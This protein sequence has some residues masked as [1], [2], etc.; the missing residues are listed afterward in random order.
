MSRS[1]KTPKPWCTLKISQH[2]TFN[3]SRIAVQ[4]LKYPLRQ[5]RL[6][7]FGLS[8]GFLSTRN[9]L[10]PL[11]TST[12]ITGRHG[13]S[14]KATFG[15]FSLHTD[16]PGAG[17]ESKRLYQKLAQNLLHSQS[18]MMSRNGSNLIHEL[19][20]NKLLVS[21]HARSPFTKPTISPC[22]RARNVVVHK[23]KD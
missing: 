16:M 4:G 10:H 9:L 17:Y 18:V 6:M 3:V 2:A 5:P 13:R 21:S 20:S 14:L 11:A 23:F 19:G 15:F 1:L 22:R 7:A 8:V 12:A